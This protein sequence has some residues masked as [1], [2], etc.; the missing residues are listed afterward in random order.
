MTGSAS[1][2][3]DV[4][5]AGGGV[6]RLSQRWCRTRHMRVYVCAS[7]N[8]VADKWMDFYIFKRH[9]SV[10]KVTEQPE[11]FPSLLGRHDEYEYEYE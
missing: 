7:Y 2:C 9:K 11:K 10:V 5:Q 3:G 4:R 1:R 8:K 6:Q